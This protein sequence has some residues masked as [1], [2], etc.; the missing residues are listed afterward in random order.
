MRGFGV[1]SGP[2]RDTWRMEGVRLVTVRSSYL[3]LTAIFGTG[4][5][6]ALLI[7]LLNPSRGLSDGATAAA[8]TA[9]APF[10]AVLW[11]WLGALLGGALFCGYLVVLLAG[12]WLSL[13]SRD[14]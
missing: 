10:L 12:A 9:G 8:L 1:V 4:V 13:T 2:V 3:L 11:T 5:L 6:V 7:A 14:A